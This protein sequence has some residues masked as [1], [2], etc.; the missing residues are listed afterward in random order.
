[1]QSCAT[2]QQQGPM[3]PVY[4]T[5]T[6]GISSL[7]YTMLLKYVLEARILKWF[8]MS[9]SGNLKW[10]FLGLPLVKYWSH[11]AKAL[12]S[13]LMGVHQWSKRGLGYGY[14]LTTVRHRHELTWEGVLERCLH[15]PKCS[16]SEKQGLL[17]VFTPF[18][19]TCT[20]VVLLLTYSMWSSAVLCS[21]FICIT[22]F[23]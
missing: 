13:I 14:I 10:T 9:D 19:C 3:V 5:F 7:Q 17:K 4:C 23:I 22:S 1:M 20:C 11:C 2:G 8:F 21:E 15:I 16:S 18:L 12:R 6:R